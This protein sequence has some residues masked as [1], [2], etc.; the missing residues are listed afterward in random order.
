ME[1]DLISKVGHGDLIG[2]GVTRGLGAWRTM[3]KVPSEATVMGFGGAPY[4][5]Q[6]SMYRDTI[7]NEGQ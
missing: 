1:Q 6:T 7:D 5:S 3:A 4:A 2:A